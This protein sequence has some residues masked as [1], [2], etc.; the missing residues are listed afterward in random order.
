M[1]HG[2][3]STKE[4]REID[5]RGVCNLQ[6]VCFERDERNFSAQAQ[7]FPENVQGGTMVEVRLEHEELKIWIKIGAHSKLRILGFGECISIE[8]HSFTWKKMNFTHNNQAVQ[9][10]YAQSFEGPTKREKYH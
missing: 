9:R 7:M 1:L 8:N 5:D 10:L 3:R 6:F 2:G 4:I